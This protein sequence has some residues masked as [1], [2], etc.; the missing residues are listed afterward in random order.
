[1]SKKSKQPMDIDN[2]QTLKDI[3]RLNRYALDERFVIRDGKTHKCAI[4]CPG[5]GYGMVCSFIEGT[6]IAKD[7]NRYGISAIIVYYRVRK[8][9]KF[10]NP[11][12]DLARAV[13]EI[14]ERKD[15]LHLDMDGYSIW[16]SSAGGHLVGSF[17]TRLM[18]YKKYQLPKP[19]LLV[20]SYPVVSL[21]SSVTHQGTR[22]NLIGKNACHEEELLKSVH[23]NID[24]SFP[25]T[26]VWCGNADQ[27]VPMTNTE[28]LRDALE[29]NRIPYRCHI[30]E[31]VDHGVGPGRGTEAEGWIDDA[32]SFWKQQL[33]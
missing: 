15:E 29:K 10:P 33:V 24:A 32:V 8:K 18:G 23:T 14:H 4:I 17:G 27:T 13:K 25:P 3:Y 12:D 7:L 30:Y 9:A 20:C 31:G 28:L 19:G 21:E 5:G 26:F 22:D 11:Q 6:P 1:M 2:K 16:G